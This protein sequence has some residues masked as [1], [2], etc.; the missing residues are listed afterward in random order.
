MMTMTMLTLWWDDDD[1]DDVMRCW[2]SFAEQENRP[3]DGN[4]EADDKDK[5]DDNDDNSGRDGNTETM[6]VLSEWR[7]WRADN[8]RPNTVAYYDVN[9][10][11]QYCGSLY[12]CFVDIMNHP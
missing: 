7:W 5:N 9:V 6:M 4:D 8:D 11:L 10:E 2:Y 12:T 1:V 3:R